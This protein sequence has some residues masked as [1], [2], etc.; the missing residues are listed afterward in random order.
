MRL[1]LQAM[2]VPLGLKYACPSQST[3]LLLINSLLTVLAIGL[4]IAYKH[5]KA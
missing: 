2:R 5:G 1:C 4:P 3:W